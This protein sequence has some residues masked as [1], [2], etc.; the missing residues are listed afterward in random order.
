MDHRAQGHAQ[1]A[2]S[3]PLR[4]Q[5]SPLCLQKNKTFVCAGAGNASPGADVQTDAGDYAGASVIAGH[6]AFAKA[7]RSAGT[8]GDRTEARRYPAARGK[9][10]NGA[11]GDCMCCGNHRRAAID[12]FDRNRS[13]VGSR[14]ECGSVVWAI[15]LDDDFSK[16]AG[17][18]LSAAYTGDQW[19]SPSALEGRIER[20][21]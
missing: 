2:V 12:S 21:G 3:D 17:G 1:R 8:V 16:R 20:S 4:A 11:G 18:L 6:L 14:I 19:W 15:S 9:D 13:V 5:L 10:P 7:R